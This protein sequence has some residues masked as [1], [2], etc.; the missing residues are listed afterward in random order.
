MDKLVGLWRNVQILSVEEFMC[1]LFW[2]EPGTVDFYHGSSKDWPKGAVPI[3]R[4]LVEDINARKFDFI[5][6]TRA[7]KLYYAHYSTIPIAFWNGGQLHKHQLLQWLD[8]KGIQSE[9]FNDTKTIVIAKQG[10][11]NE[12]TAQIPTQ[13]STIEEKTIKTAD[14]DNET[15][16]QNLAAPIDPLSSSSAEQQTRISIN[17]PISLWGGKTPQAIF[18]S[19]SQAKFAPEV[20]AYVLMKNG[21]VTKT[22]AGRMFYQGAR[23]KGVEQEPRTYQRKIDNLLKRA[24]SKYSFAFKG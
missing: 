15:S 6:E 9:F 8:E 20:I 10:K 11:D 14:A 16:P 3:Y 12:P 19:L 5:F 23:D 18:D 24:N 7:E 2:L 22:D 21:G 4:T 13:S 17:V 1:L